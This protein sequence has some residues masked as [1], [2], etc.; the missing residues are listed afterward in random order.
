MVQARGLGKVN[1]YLLRRDGLLA[2]L[3]EL[4]DGLGVVAEIL[5]ATNKNDGQALAEVH[6]LRDPLSKRVSR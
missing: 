1:A 3:A 2:R 4:L 5:L 6:D